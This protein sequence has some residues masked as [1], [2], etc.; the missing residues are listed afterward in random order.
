M[1]LNIFPIAHSVEEVV[2]K[3]DEQ[4]ICFFGDWKVEQSESI[5]DWFAFMD[6]FFDLPDRS[7]EVID[8]LLLFTP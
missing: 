8:F 5:A 7:K 2:L 1:A 3:C 6:S 4:G